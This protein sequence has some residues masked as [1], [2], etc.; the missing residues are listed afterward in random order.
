MERVN[1]S[2][3]KIIGDI[4][5]RYTEIQKS[6]DHCAKLVQGKDIRRWEYKISE[7]QTKINHMLDKL[8]LEMQRRRL[9]QREI[10]EDKAEASKILQRILHKPRDLRSP[11]VGNTSNRLENPA[12]I[13]T[14]VLRTSDPGV[15][16]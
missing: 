8:E 7:S 12:K 11:P 13:P 4:Q 14:N 6:K 16:L 10:A 5:L 9:R 3:L 15:S 1:S 2:I